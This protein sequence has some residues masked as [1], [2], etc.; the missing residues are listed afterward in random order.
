MSAQE[1][2]STLHTTTT[3]VL[4][5]YDGETVIFTCETRNSR[6][7][8]WSS[9]DYIGTGGTRLELTDVESEGTYRN[10]STGRASAVLISVD[11]SVQGMTIL[12]SQLH[13]AIVSTYQTSSVTCH[14]VGGD[15]SNTITFYMR[16]M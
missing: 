11:R 1:L 3:G 13:I 15:E 4:V 5:A 16:G 9:N 2:N 14:S 8:A 6:T 12:V 7:I 10:A